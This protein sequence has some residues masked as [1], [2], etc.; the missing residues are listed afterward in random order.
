M[1]LGDEIVEEIGLKAQDVAMVDIGRVYPT[2]T[3]FD[4]DDDSG[5][6]C[7]R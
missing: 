6:T 4:F 2:A 7:R 3:T 5:I 1:G